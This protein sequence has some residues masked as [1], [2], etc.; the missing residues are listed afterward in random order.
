MVLRK[1]KY[2]ATSSALGA[3]IQVFQHVFTLGDGVIGCR[4]RQVFHSSY[5]FDELM[6]W[7]YFRFHLEC[8]CSTID[9]NHIPDVR[10]V[11]IGSLKLVGY[12]AALSACVTKQFSLCHVDY[13]NSRSPPFRGVKGNQQSKYYMVQTIGR[14]DA[15]F[16]PSIFT[17]IV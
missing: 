16:N 12:G 8:I 11:E 15:T 17:V 1:L 6:V 10:P 5:I 7:C 14:H 2:V 9:R 4:Q 13:C 3:R